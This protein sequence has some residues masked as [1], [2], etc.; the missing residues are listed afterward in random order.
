LEWRKKG[1]RDEFMMLA[2]PVNAPDF[3]LVMPAKRW[4]GF[5]L[6]V[7]AATNNEKE[8]ALMERILAACSFRAR[9]DGFGRLPIPELAAKAAGIT[10]QVWIIGRVE[11]YELWNPAR[12]EAAMASPDVKRIADILDTVKT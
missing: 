8:S 1:Q 2:S 12:W 4:P 5:L 7:E 6:R 11:K 3:L 10:D 9:L